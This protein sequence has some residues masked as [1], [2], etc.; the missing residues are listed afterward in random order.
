MRL[1][2]TMTRDQMDELSGLITHIS[3]MKHQRLDDDE[4]AAFHNTMMFHFEMLD[5]LGVPFFIQNYALYLGEEY[6][7]R[8]HYLAW[9]FDQIRTAFENAH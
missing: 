8:N 6:D 1:D 3:I 5:K 2:T 7:I 9:Y 4:R